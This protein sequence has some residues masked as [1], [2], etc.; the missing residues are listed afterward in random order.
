VTKAFKD[1][2]DNGKGGFI[3]IGLALFFA[4]FIEFVNIM[5]LYAFID[6]ARPSNLESIFRDWI[7]SLQIT[8]FPMFRIDMPLTEYDG[9]FARPEIFERY[10]F[11]FNILSS[12]IVFAAQIAFF[13]VL[14]EVL[15]WI[16]QRLGNNKFGNIMRHRFG[17]AAYS[18]GMECYLSAAINFGFCGA[19]VLLDT[20]IVGVY[21]SL[22]F[23]CAIFVV[24]LTGIT[25]VAHPIFLK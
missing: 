4:D 14:Y 10:D 23:A 6:I 17:P 18:N 16:S 2:A 1:L 22:N 24:F 8:P 9:L 5:T 7:S 13:V 21:K 11:S 15:T 20:R 12:F 25:A 3:L 19:A